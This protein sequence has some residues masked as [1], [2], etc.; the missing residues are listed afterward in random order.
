MLDLKYNPVARTCQ[1]PLQLK[2]NGGVFIVN[3]FGRQAEPP[4]K[5]VN[6]WIVPLDEAALIH[7]IKVKYP[8]IDNRF[9]NYQPIFLIDQMIAI[10]DFEG[11]ADQMSPALID[12]A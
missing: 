7:L 11:I 4:Q 6:R 8:T 12:R 2:S 10:C 9:A 5:R 3:D 1:A